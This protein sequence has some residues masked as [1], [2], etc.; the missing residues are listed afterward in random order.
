M[1]ILV[2][3]WVKLTRVDQSET[4]RRAAPP[5][6]NALAKLE[7]GPKGCVAG[8]KPTSPCSTTIHL[9]RINLTVMSCSIASSALR[10]PELPTLKPIAAC[11][12]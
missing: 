10:R 1:T 5:P 9:D 8:L 4:R 2:V 3:S 7:Q 11:S 12:R 6:G